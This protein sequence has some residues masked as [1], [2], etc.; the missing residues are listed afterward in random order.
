MNI[1]I[2]RENLTL[3]FLILILL[4]PF[5]PVTLINSMQIFDVLPLIEGV[6]FA[7]VYFVKNKGVS[8]PVL[9]GI[10]F[11]SS[12]ALSTF[13]YG[14]NPLFPAFFYGGRMLAF[15][16]LVE[17]FNDK[18][19]MLI[20]SIKTYLFVVLLINQ[21]F[22]FYDQDYWGKTG[23]GNFCNF[24]VSDNQLPFFIL[25]FF[26]V[27]V[28]DTYLRGK[29]N[30]I[31]LAIGI[32]LGC[33]VIF[34]A[35]AVSGIIAVFLCAFL[36][37]ISNLEI[38]KRFFTYRKVYIVVC[39]MYFV[40][41]FLNAIKYLD[42]FT[43]KYFGKTLARSRTRIW[44]AALRNIQKRLLLGYGTV[45]GGRL[46]INY[47]G[48]NHWFAHNFVLEVLVQG[49]I[50]LLCIFV[51]AFV[52]IAVRNSN[53]DEWI[54][55]KWLCIVFSLLVACLTEGTIVEPTQY[56]ILLL[57]YYMKEFAK[58]SGSYSNGKAVY[59]KDGKLKYEFN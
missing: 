49:G 58:E 57:G 53:V 37:I 55:M 28:F 40:V 35:H 48:K 18:R 20:G 11:S 26:A 56:L 12:L 45:K 27:L 39:S 50:I 46:S 4:V 13:C 5:Y 36:I 29:K 34:R 42:M 2:E 30:S 38:A 14:K 6:V 3:F 23:A 44:A 17:I 10:L 47:V 22:Q 1:Q 31:G 9:W 32:V 41:V 15:I 21:F 7:L 24:F 59:Y 51:L 43:S 25:E 19:L 52:I 33:V 16:F 54:R 8:Y